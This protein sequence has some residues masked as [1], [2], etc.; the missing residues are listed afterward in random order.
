[1][2]VNLLERMPFSTLMGVELIEATPSLVRASLVVRPDL[3]TTGHHVHGGALMAFADAIGGVG[4]Y[5]NLPEGSKGTTTIES[6]TNFLA[7]AAEGAILIGEA[8]PVQV[9]RRISV[10]Q[11]RIRL[12]N[13]REVALVTQTQLVL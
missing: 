13:G 1:M 3:C 2:T 5:L 10:W 7:A 4:A 6:K 8:T 12:D 9:G 11:T